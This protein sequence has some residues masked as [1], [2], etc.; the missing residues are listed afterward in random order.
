VDGLADTAKGVAHS[1]QNLA[2][3]RLIVPQV[4]QPRASGVAHSVQN[5]AP[6]G[7]W[8]PH[9]EQVTQAL[10]DDMKL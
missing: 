6:T 1:A 8:E 5:F 10:R 9:W 3:G 2:V 4:G 7:F